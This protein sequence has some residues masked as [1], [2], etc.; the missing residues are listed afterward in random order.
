MAR[1]GS[2]RS[3]TGSA[4]HSTMASDVYAYFNN[5]WHGNAVSDATYLR[6]ALTSRVA[7]GA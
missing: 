3:S 5:D 2:T 1:L 7:H 4:Q 6:A